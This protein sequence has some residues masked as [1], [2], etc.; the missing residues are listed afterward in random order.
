MKKIK[1]QVVSTKMDKTITVTVDTLKQHRRYK[2]YVKKRSKFYAHDEEERA[3][4]GDEVLIRET[5]PIS[6]KKKWKLEK[7][8]DE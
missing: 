2:K 7:I 1:G 4:E 6:R 5:R 3:E 8:I